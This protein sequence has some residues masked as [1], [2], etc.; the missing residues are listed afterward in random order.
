MRG[1]NVRNCKETKAIEIGGIFM[2]GEEEAKR[3]SS[4]LFYAKKEGSMK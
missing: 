1:L 4:V 3:K 2:D